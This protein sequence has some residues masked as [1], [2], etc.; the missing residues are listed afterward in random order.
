LTR[1]LPKEE[2]L[3]KDLFNSKPPKILPKKNNS[4]ASG[5]PTEESVLIKKDFKK[6]RSRSMKSRK[7]RTRWVGGKDGVKGAAK[8]LTPVGKGH[9][10]K[11]WGRATRTRKLGAGGR[12][13]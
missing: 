12:K 8:S 10:K 7:L 1:G 6:G 3:L 13:H 2:D 5:R 11:N 9:A 4:G